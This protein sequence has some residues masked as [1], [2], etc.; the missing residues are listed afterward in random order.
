M[1]ERLGDSHELGE[2]LLF[3]FST[4]SSVP[5]WASETWER[6]AHRSRLARAGVEKPVNRAATGLTSTE[7]NAPASQ[8]WRASGGL[9]LAPHAPVRGE[10]SM[11]GPA[12]LCTLRRR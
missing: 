9:V 12:L 7:R 10:R 8:P 5:V 11:G 4:P 3:S 1:A 6:A 2:V